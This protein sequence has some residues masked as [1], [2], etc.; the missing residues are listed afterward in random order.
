MLSCESAAASE[1]K[2]RASGERQR[3]RAEIEEALVQ[4]PLRKRR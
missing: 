4:P 2:R 1:V 3:E